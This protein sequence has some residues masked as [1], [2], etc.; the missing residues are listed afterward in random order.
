[1]QGRL[2]T[3][4]ERDRQCVW[5][6]FPRTT[7][8]YGCVTLHRYHFYGDQGLPQQQVLLGVHGQEL[9]AVF[10]QVLGAA[11][12][13]HYD[14][15]AGKVKDIRSSQVYPRPFAA[16]QA[17][18]SLLELNPRESM[19]VYRPKSLIPQAA[20]PFHAEQLWLFERVRL[21]ERETSW[22][23]SVSGFTYSL[24]PH[25]SPST[26]YCST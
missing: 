22:V 25:F 24:R 5:A 12:H 15:R 23:P 18:G 20:L 21:A 14:L 17:Q 16:R 13:C 8:R 3:P 6:L 4:Q 10:D 1:V 26:T 7:N 11:Y 9:R 19:V 2:Y